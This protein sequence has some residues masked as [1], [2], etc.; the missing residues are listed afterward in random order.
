MGMKIIEQNLN[1]SFR[2]SGNGFFWIY[3]YC[4]R[5][6]VLLLWTK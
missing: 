3:R 1:V 4:H 6:Q 2:G 5:C